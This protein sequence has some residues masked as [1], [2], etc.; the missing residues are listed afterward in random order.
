[1]RQQDS[2]RV[3]ANSLLAN[4]VLGTTDGFYSPPAT[5]SWHTS[6]KV[7]VFTQGQVQ[8]GETC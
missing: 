1:M 3:T 2:L 8:E 5:V 6:A 7:R 4:P